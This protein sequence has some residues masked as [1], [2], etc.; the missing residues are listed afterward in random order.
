MEDMTSHE[1]VIKRFKQEGFRV[2]PHKAFQISRD[3]ARVRMLLVS[4]MHDKLVK[5]LLLTPAGSI[6][7]ALAAALPDLPADARVGIMPRA[8]S[9][10]PYIA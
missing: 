1:S 10:M 3:A 8:S 7:Q 6:D 5:R 2:G 9:T 4:Q